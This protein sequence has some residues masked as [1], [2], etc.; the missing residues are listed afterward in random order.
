MD[1]TSKLKAVINSAL[2][3]AADTDVE[4][5]R[6]IQKKVRSYED[7]RDLTIEQQTVLTHAIAN[8]H[9]EAKDRITAYRSDPIACAKLEKHKKQLANLY[10]YI[11]SMT[12]SG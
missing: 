8:L 4:T 2:H 1:Y 6:I 7:V 9:W 5:I 3:R 10:Y 12:L 11:L